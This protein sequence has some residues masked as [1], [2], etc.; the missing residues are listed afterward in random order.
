MPPSGD[1]RF[2]PRL[3]ELARRSGA[4]P[5]AECREFNDAFLRRVGV[6]ERESRPLEVPFSGLLGAPRLLATLGE[7]LGG[8]LEG[9]GRGEERGDLAGDDRE[10]ESCFSECDKS[11]SSLLT[12]KL[13][14]DPLRRGDE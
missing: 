5:L 6:A 11:V 9:E 12:F 7:R 3:T 2:E 8:A 10:S 4:T 13:L 1:L 14:V